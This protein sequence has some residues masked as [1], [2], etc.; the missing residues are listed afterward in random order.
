M[1]EASYHGGAP[2]LKSSINLA[3]LFLGIYEVHGGCG[4]DL[5]P[6]LMESSWEGMCGQEA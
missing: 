6:A 1:V 3:N 2:A 5:G 4:P